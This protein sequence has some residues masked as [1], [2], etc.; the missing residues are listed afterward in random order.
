MKTKI[1]LTCYPTGRG[2]GAVKGSSVGGDVMGYALGEDGHG[3]CSHYSSGKGYS[4]HDMGLTSNWKHDIYEECYPEGFE[5]I[6]IDD[7]DNSE[8]WKKAY[9][10]NQADE[11]QEKKK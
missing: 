3:L 11:K 1:Y 8:E 9:S 2:S 6:W 10:L 5:L 4:K 7:P